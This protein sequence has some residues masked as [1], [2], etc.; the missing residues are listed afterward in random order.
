MARSEGPPWWRRGPIYQIYPRSFCDSD[1]DGVGDLP[2][3]ATRLDHL[4]GAPNSLGVEAV[5]LSPFY[6]SP[7]ADGGYDICDHTALDP[8]FGSLEHFDELVAQARARGIRVVV[9]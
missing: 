3:I 2:G 9:D 1:G 5:W 7:M 6:R 8:L 4:R